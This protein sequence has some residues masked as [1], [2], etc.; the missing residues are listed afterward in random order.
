MMGVFQGDDAIPAHRAG[1]L[2]SLQYHLP[3]MTEDPQ[4]P[5]YGDT[6]LRVVAEY[7]WRFRPSP[8]PSLREM[9]LRVAGAADWAL[10]AGSGI[11]NAQRSAEA[12]LT[13]E[14]FFGSGLFVRRYSGQDYYNIN[15]TKRL[16][17]TQ[18]GVAIRYERPQQFVR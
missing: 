1:L 17:V 10:N 6:R 5:L 15:F 12:S 18:V 8:I 7:A 16:N 2:V 14:R 13:S 9:I 4:K 11:P 3:F